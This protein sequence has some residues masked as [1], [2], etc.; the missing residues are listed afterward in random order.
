MSKYDYSEV[1]W[2]I[3]NV[4]AHQA[5]ELKEIGK[6]DTS[7]LDSRISESE[8]LLKSLG[9][10]DQLTALKTSGLQVPAEQPHKVMVVP[11]WEILSF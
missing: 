11:S 2:Q 1:E 4:L 8:E 7:N 3:N 9:Y 5:K 10:G 6:L